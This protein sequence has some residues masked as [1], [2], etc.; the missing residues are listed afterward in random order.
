MR[1]FQVFGGMQAE[2]ATRMLRTL[3]KA[4]PQVFREALD[5]AALASKSRPTYLRSQPFE[6][7]AQAVRRALSRVASNVLADEILAVY[8]LEC[9]K[10]LLVEWL[11]VAGLAHED[12]TLEEEE[13]AQPEEATLS[14]AVQKFLGADDDEDRR[15]LL[16]AFSAQQ[17]ID[18]PLLDALLAEEP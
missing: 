11:D 18:W 14:A 10:E 4:V 12:G 5:A 9:R 16:R 7:R 1:S 2:H 17:A 15:L 8:F 3:S 13:P 6:R